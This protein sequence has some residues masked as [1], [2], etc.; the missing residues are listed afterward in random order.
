[1][2]ELDVVITANSDDFANSIKIVNSENNLSTYI[3][4]KF[5]LSF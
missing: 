1:M 4:T 3:Q 2:C 5:V